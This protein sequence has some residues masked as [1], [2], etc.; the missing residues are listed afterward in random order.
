MKQ[1]VAPLVDRR[2][3]RRAFARAAAGYDDAAFLA[4]EVAARMAERLDYIRLEPGRILDLGCGTGADLAAL[5]SRYPTALTTGG[6]F[7]PAMLEVARRKF[8]LSGPIAS[9]LPSWLGG[10]AK[11]PA[12]AGVDALSLPFAP[13]SFSLLWSNLMLHWLDDPEPVLKELH[14]VMEVDGLLMFS[15]LGPDTLK[16]LRAVFGDGYAHTQRFIDM[17]DWGDLLLHCGFADPVVDMEIITLTY[18]DLDA[19]AAELKG[20]GDTCAMTARRSG[21]MSPAV[22]RGAREAFARQ[23]REGRTPVTV[24]VVYG[25]AWK[26][27]PKKTADGRSIVRFDLPRAA[28]K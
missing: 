28:K 1:A 12:L 9:R 16:E 7:V 5:Q 8:P 3:V 17:H 25:H 27:A 11:G 19:L 24:E 26:A 2:Q 4:R 13:A 23:S 15:T 20:C 14:R 6:D 22:W 18:P 21:L 10:A